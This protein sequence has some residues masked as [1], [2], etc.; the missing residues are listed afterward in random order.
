ML[1]SLPLTEFCA[2]VW[3]KVGL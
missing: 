2:S 1:K 3:H